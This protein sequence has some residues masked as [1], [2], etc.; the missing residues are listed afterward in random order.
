MAL[1]ELLKKTRDDLD[2]TTSDAEVLVALTNFLAALSHDPIITSPQAAQMLRDIATKSRR[3][4][5]A[6][7]GN[8]QEGAI[9]E[10]GVPTVQAAEILQKQALE[11]RRDQANKEDGR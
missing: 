6:F 4:S 2:Q 7:L 5:R 8:A 10:Q 9:G 1:I 11:Y 3:T